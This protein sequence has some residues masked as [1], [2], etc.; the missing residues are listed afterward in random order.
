MSLGVPVVPVRP[1]QF[2]RFRRAPRVPGSVLVGTAGRMH[3]AK[4]TCFGRVVPSPDGFRVLCRE[5]PAAAVAVACQWP[6]DRITG[7]A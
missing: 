7:Q 1:N 6:A 2:D 3:W 5:V 4:V